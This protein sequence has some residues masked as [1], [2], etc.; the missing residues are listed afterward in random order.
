M[1][2]LGRQGVT[3]RRRRCTSPQGPGSGR[4]TRTVCARRFRGGKANPSMG[5]TSSYADPR[6]LLLGDGAGRVQPLGP[7]WAMSAGRR[8]S[9]AV[10]AGDG[11]R[12][13][14]GARR[15]PPTAAV[16]GAGVH[17][18]RRGRHP[19]IDRVGSC[20]DNANAESL[21]AQSS[22]A[23]APRSRAAGRPRRDFT[24]RALRSGAIRR[25]GLSL[26]SRSGLFWARARL[27]SDNAFRRRTAAA[28]SGFAR[29]SCCG[30]WSPA[31]S[32]AGDPA[33]S[34]NPEFPG[35]PPA[36]CDPPA[37][38]AAPPVLETP[39]PLHIGLAHLQRHLLAPRSVHEQPV[40]T[41]LRA[42]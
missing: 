35:A 30:T 33:A 39:S 8:W 17:Q 19:A 6:G 41:S 36:R 5:R 37:A 28:G 24:W 4:G 12:D 14:G 16:H 21:F 38:P 1:R 11:A 29:P 10:S 2:A 31:G 13:A 9:W 32:P 40:A 7:C 34:R 15:V 26:P 20:F 22:A 25:Y 18:R 42:A 3:R 23:A 27:R